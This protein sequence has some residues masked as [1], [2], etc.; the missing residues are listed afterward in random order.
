MAS[1]SET[2]T[3]RQIGNPAGDKLVS[4]AE[5]SDG[6]EELYSASYAQ[7]LETLAQENAENREGGAINGHPKTV[8]S[9]DQRSASHRHCC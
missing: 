8:E 3:T 7:K 2:V 6:I 9:F 1:I 5:I 4:S